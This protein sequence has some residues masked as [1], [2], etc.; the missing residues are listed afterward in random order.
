MASAIIH[1]CVAKEINKKL[2]MN[3]K[4]LYLGAIAPDISKQIGENK[5]KSHFLTTS[6]EDV[7][8][9]YQFLNKYKHELNN[10]FNMG[11]FIHLYTDKIWF[12]E[13]LRSKLYE[14]CIKLLDGT[15]VNTTQQEKLRIIYN[16]YTNL[17]IQ[18]IDDYELDLSLFYE[19]FKKPQTTIE[20]IPIDRL[21]ILL[22][23]M[24]L[25]IMESKK[26]K[27]YVFDVLAIKN[28]INYCTDKILRKIEE[29]KI[30]VHID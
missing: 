21:P 15:S 9:I 4:E 24:S 7:P 5:N 18:L 28:F 25:I 30:K 2:K 29:Y 17:N 3:E 16:D 6:E 10:P 14:N 23:K 19:K 22:D 12:A 20:E 1:I 13:F 27:V 11:Y 26:E 8:N